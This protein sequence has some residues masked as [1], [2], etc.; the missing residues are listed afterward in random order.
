MKSILTH[1]KSKN[2]RF[3][4]AESNINAATLRN[5]CILCVRNY[6]TLRFSIFSANRAIRPPFYMS[7]HIHTALFSQSGSLWSRMQTVFPSPDS[8]CVIR[9]VVLCCRFLWE[10]CASKCEWDRDLHCERE[11]L[12]RFIPLV[13]VRWRLCCLSV[14]MWVFGVGLMLIKIE[15]MYLPRQRRYISLVNI[16][17]NFSRHLSTH[18]EALGTEYATDQVVTG[19]SAASVSGQGMRVNVSVC[20]GC[21]TRVA[22]LA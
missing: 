14:L 11:R 13:S 1:R 8:L 10:C 7:P 15:F 2:I 21:V 22:R 20:V 4:A 18:G 12:F 19:R 3:R 6:F 17:V 5:G 16:G 9:C